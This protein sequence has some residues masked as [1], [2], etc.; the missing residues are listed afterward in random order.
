MLTVRNW[1]WARI[2]LRTSSVLA[3]ARASARAYDPQRVVDHR[4]TNNKAPWRN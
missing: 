2:T 1:L 4:I 3:N